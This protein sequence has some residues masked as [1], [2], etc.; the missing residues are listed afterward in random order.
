MGRQFRTLAGLAVVMGLVFALAPS[1][2]E[3]H[4]PTPTP[5]TPRADAGRVVVD[6]VDGSSEHD[7]ERIERL[8]GAELDWTHPESVDEAL[9]EGWVDDV[10]RAVRMLEGNPLVEVAEPEIVLRAT[11]YPNDPMYDRQ[12][13]LK[14]MGAPEGW[15]S[16]ARG[17]GV[18]VAVVDTGVARVED[19]EGTEML[20][21]ESFVPGTRSSTDDQGHGTH[22]AGTIAQTTN[23][24]KG[25]AG[26]AP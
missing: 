21:G 15:A 6:L 19:L 17:E 5:P 12:W 1:D 11:N 8:L 10:D 2:P 26:V 7:L 3:R 14:A 4:L 20:K 23:N 22:V 24:G 13:H 18:V 16:T 9:A 25:V